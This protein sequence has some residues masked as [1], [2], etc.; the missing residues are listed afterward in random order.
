MG[1]PPDSDVVLNINVLFVTTC[2]V[3]YVPLIENVDNVPF[4]MR[5]V[6]FKLKNK[7][8]KTPIKVLKIALWT[9]NMTSRNSIGV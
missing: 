1:L 8:Q 3:C 5:V 6:H 2:I 7:S 4:W 9:R